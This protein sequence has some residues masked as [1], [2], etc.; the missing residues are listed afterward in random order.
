[1]KTAFFGDN[2]DLL[3]YEILKHILGEA[4]YENYKDV[5]EFLKIEG[6]IEKDI[7]YLY[8]KLYGSK[9]VLYLLNKN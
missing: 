9:K 6:E 2:L 1:M 4:T 8:F 7:L 5:I 3:P